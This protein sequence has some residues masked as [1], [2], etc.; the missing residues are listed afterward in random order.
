[1][2]FFQTKPN[3]APLASCGGAL[4][5]RNYDTKPNLA[6]LSSQRGER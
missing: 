3:F 6:P 1:M 5:G 2:V 4:Q